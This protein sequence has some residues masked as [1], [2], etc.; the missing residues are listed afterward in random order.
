MDLLMYGGNEIEISL[1]QTGVS[2]RAFFCCY[3][4][5][6]QRNISPDEEFTNFKCINDSI[7]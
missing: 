6:K 1:Q 7:A 4:E 3:V 2:N 5:I